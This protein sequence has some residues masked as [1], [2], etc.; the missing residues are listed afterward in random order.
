MGAKGGVSHVRVVGWIR[1]MG[2]RLWSW[3]KQRGRQREWG[4]V[5]MLR[6]ISTRLLHTGVVGSEVRA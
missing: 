6:A 2:Y 3:G 4:Q 5:H 1:S